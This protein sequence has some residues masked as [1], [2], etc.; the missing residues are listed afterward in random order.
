MRTTVFLGAACAIA[1]LG[2][3]GTVAFGQAPNQAQ[4]VTRP[5]AG[6]QFSTL[7]GFVIERMNPADRKDS[8][9]MLTFDSFGRPVVSKE[10][11]HPRV[12][13]DADKDGVFESEKVLTD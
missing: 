7:P 6:V 3:A 5:V 12:L 8:Y 2:I 11:D 1:G 13:L 10:Q 4:L 9:V